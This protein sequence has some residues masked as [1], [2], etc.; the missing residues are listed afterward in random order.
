MP[1]MARVVAAGV[2][3]HITQRGNNRQITFVADRDRRLYLD[4]ILEECQRC[5]IRVLGYCLMSNHVH[6]VAI[7]DFADS[8]ARSLRKAHSRYAR[9]F[10]LHYGRSGHL[11]QSRY[12]S[13][14]LDADHLVQ[15][16]AYV[17]LNPVRA[18]I[19]GEPELYPWSSARPHAGLERSPLIDEAGWSEI[20][21]PQDRRALTA[22]PVTDQINADIREATY[23]GRPLGNEALISSLE[24]QAGRILRRR[25]PGPKPKRH[26]A[27]R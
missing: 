14:P 22:G 18:G 1:R 9:A 23:G 10:N 27:S 20:Q 5:G 3:H 11:W 21:G 12:Y 24:R 17:D 7:P 2:P 13:C 15:A 16:L 6:F 8:F 4:L 25:K 26:A 19:V